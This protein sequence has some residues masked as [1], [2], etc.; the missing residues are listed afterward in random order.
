MDNFFTG[1]MIFARFIVPSTTCCTRLFCAACRLQ[2]ALVVAVVVVV[3]VVGPVILNLPRC[4]VGSG[5]YFQG[6]HF[7]R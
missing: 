3:V 2:N 5:I 4:M 6:F 7:K 1:V